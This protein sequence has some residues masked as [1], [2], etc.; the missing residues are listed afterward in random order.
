MQ[1]GCFSFNQWYSVIVCGIF[2]SSLF[3]NFLAVS[4]RPTEC[5]L[6]VT[7][8]W[9]QRKSRRAMTSERKNNFLV[10]CSAG[11]PLSRYQINSWLLSSKVMLFPRNVLKI[12]FCLSLWAENRDSFLARDQCGR[13]KV[14][15]WQD[16]RY[17][18]VLMRDIRTNKTENYFIKCL[19]RKSG[20]CFKT[21]L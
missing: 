14:N 12:S 18:V 13:K 4:G 15:Y 8:Q 3:P 5:W 9:C 19:L 16:Y 2:N 11:S 6:S 7:P 21:Q 1:Y 17:F 10:I 20:K